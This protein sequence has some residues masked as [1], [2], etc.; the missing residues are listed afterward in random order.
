MNRW[1]SGIKRGDLDKIA[2]WVAL[3]L[4]VGTT[5]TFNGA[6]LA[7]AQDATYAPGSGYASAQPFG[8]SV[9]YDSANIGLEVG[10]A[11]SSYID[12]SAQASG[13]TFA[14]GLFSL[15]TGL[16][17]CGSDPVPPGAAQAL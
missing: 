16:Q 15:M 9:L 13:A 6:G 5:V 4:I 8:I 1:S 14:S 3:A 17:V 2:F 12:S 10:Q 7:A 11:A